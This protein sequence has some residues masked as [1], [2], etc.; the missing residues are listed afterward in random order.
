MGMIGPMEIALILGAV[1]IFFFGKG[2]VIEWAKAIGE[3]KKAY[4]EANS[5]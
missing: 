3:T 5:E 2:K 4:K 1:A